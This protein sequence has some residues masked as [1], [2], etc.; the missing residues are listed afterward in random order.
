MPIKM[1]PVSSL[2]KVFLDEA[3]TEMPKEVLS[4][5]KGE[6]LSFQIAISGTAP[7]PE[8][9]I[10]WVEAACDLPF[11]IRLVGQVP[12]RFPAHR[13]TEGAYLRKSPGLYPDPLQDLQG[14][15]SRERSLG[16]VPAY[17]DQW[18]ALWVDI[19]I[20]KEREAGSYA[21]EL[22]LINREGES[23]ADIS[24]HIQVVDAL[25]PEQTL[26]H[27]RWL[28]CDALADHYGLEMFSDAYFEVLKNYLAVMASR[29]GNMV[30]TPIH[31]PPLDTREGNERRTAQL[32]DVFVDGK[33]AY[34]FRFDK[35][36]RFV[37][38]AQDAGI[39]YF[40]MAHLFTQW[41][42][43]HAPK[44]VGMK[45]GKLQ[46][47]FGWHSDAL[48]KG[49]QTF[50][51]AYL[52]A[53]VGELRKMDILHRSYFHISD[54]PGNEHLEQYRA[55]RES[56]LPY[57][58]GVKMIDALSDYSFYEQGLVPLP[59]PATDHIAPFLKADIPER[60][61]YY[62][63]SQHRKVSNCF[64]AMPGARTRVLGVQCYLYQIQ[65]F[66][67]WGYNFWYSQYAD[68]PVNPWQITDA[69]GF[70]PSGDA[71]QV[72][73]GKNGK[74]VESIRLM[75]FFQ[76]MQDLRALTALE[77]K[78]GRDE[79]IALIKEGLAEL[80]TLEDYPVD[81]EWLQDLRQRVNHALAG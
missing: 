20:D 26:I 69:D 42:A 71:F 56:V 61:A 60:W 5:L 51:A 8:R 59:V 40:E 18:Q 16:I 65:G 79:V 48:G 52:P 24:Q 45:D 21:F 15:T 68:Y 53:V 37:S 25:L 46:T 27:T 70:A 14:Q 74:P 43:Y 41:G 73:P 75:H 10:L 39:Q 55:V 76:A 50:L 19:Q 80:P 35:L 57:L 22:K 66:L 58:K 36:R 72:Y 28:H 54:E 29:G 12:V 44:I 49:Y 34:S 64:I 30:L 7:M 38:V 33:G 11:R 62:C 6:T 77:E 32:V 17:R 4:G 3:P 78:I 1:Y 9:E 81:D 23:A 13:D 2:T 47:L 67:Q 63:V 31:T